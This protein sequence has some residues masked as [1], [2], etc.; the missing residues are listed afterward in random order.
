[1]ALALKSTTTGG[2]KF[3]YTEAEKNLAHCVV[4]SVLTFA[5]FTHPKPKTEPLIE[6]ML[7]LI[8]E[9]HTGVDTLSRALFREFIKDMC[10][11]GEDFHSS[12]DFPKERD[13]TS[14]QLLMRTGIIRCGRSDIIDQVFAKYGGYK[15]KTA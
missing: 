13:P 7:D 12:A 6:Q 9:G 11:S 3:E 1:M 5:E 14:I 4:S 2:G 10:G 15:K 8:K